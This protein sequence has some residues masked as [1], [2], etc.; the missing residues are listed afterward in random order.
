MKF[1][2]YFLQCVKKQLAL[3]YANHFWRTP[4]I[5]TVIDTRHAPNNCTVHKSKRVLPMC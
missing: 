1:N 2:Q 4:H 3:I 5:D